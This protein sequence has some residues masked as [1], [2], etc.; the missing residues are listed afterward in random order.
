RGATAGAGAPW[1]ADRRH[2]RGRPRRARGA[3]GDGCLAQLRHD[4]RRAAARGVDGDDR[5]AGRARRAGGSGRT[6]RADDRPLDRLGNRRMSTLIMGIVNVT[7]DSFSDGGRYLA[8]DAA[9]ARGL[10]LRA[11]GAAYV[12]VG[13]EATRPGS[14]R[15]PIDVQ[16]ERVLPVLRALATSAAAVS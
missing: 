12:D 14:E 1:R 4:A 3:G 6:R 15:A 7:P 13:G 16:L 2:D 10:G 8:A 5:R 9:I 11:E